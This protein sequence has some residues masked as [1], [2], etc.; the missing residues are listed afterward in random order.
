VSTRAARYAPVAALLAAGLMAQA[1]QSRRPPTPPPIPEA[2]DR[3]AIERHTIGSEFTLH[4]EE[5]QQ[6]LKLQPAQ[7]AAWDAYARRV[8]ALMQDQLRGV[9]RGPDDEDALHQINRRVDIVRNRLAAME[10][11][12]DAAAQLYAVLSPEQRKVADELL[13][14]TV[15][16]LY[17]GLPEFPR[18]PVILRK[19]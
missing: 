15:P 12:A 10:D 8:Q 6:R 13:P 3:G 5:V 4:V 1:Q 9:P 18:G 7:Q 16:A 17:S 11:I 2:P 14:T 19:K